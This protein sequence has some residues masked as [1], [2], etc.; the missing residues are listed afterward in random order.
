MFQEYFR[1]SIFTF[2]SSPFELF[3]KNGVLDN[4]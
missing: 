1:K 2:R 4:K 3:D